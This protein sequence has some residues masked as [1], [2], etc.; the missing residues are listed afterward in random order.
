MLIGGVFVAEPL[1]HLF[2]LT[3]RVIGELDQITAREHLTPTDAVN[4]AI[5]LYY[6]V[7]NPKRTLMILED[8]GTMS[9]VELE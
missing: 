2:M 1:P 9:S 6:F 7:A 5:S 3:P 8:D 4:R